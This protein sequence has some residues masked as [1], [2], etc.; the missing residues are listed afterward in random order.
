M[1]RLVLLFSLVSMM[2]CGG[3]PEAEAAPAAATTAAAPAAPA[4]AAPPVAAS[5]APAAAAPGALCTNTC[6]SA[7]DGDCDDGGPGSEYD[8]CELGSDCADCGARSAAAA[9]AAAAATA[10]CSNTCESA[11]DGE[12]DDGGPG[13]EYDVCALGTDCTDCGAR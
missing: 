6:A 4:P 3:E 9:P 11:G 10:G 13:S 2:A 8:I 12:C 7:G 1:T 5:A